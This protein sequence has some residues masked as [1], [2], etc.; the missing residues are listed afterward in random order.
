MKTDKNWQ[1]LCAAEDFSHVDFQNVLNN[2]FQKPATYHRKQW[3]F[4]V[5]YLNLLANNKIEKDMVGASFG[6]G[7]EPLIYLIGSQ[8][9]E[10][11]A[12][13]LYVFNTGWQTAKINE[14]QTCRD[15]VMEK[16]P[17]NLDVSGILVEEM[18]MRNLDFADSSLDFCYSS[19]AFEH[20]GHE[21]DFIKHLEEV[22]RVL[23]ED[24]VYVMTTEYLFNHQTFKIKGNYKFDTKYM[25]KLFEASGLYP[26][27]VFDTSLQDSILNKTKMDLSPI[28][29]MGTA[30]INSIPSIILEKQGVPYT[31]CCFVLRKNNIKNIS[32]D[33]LE[34]KNTKDF[35]VKSLNKNIFKL[36]SQYQYLN[37]ISGLKKST[38][39][40]MADHLEYLGENFDEYF[41]EIKIESKNFLHTDFVYFGSFRCKFWI[42]V[43]CKKDIKCEIKLFEKDSLYVT[44]R[45]LVKS[46]TLD[47]SAGVE[48]RLMDFQCK[49]DKVYAVAVSTDQSM[50]FIDFKNTSIRVKVE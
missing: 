29:S 30:I 1:K 39:S 11:T 37:P 47:G 23:K 50:N 12:T 27:P 41:D 15:F 43:E 31:S 10:F 21:D 44:G 14:Q 49:D 22:K 32:L 13:D 9:K 24:G 33:E 25:L 8:V 18:D 2:I 40:V 35:V 42:H 17:K 45:V 34:N 38:K 4:V 26:D 6:A 36:Y 48:D 16:A 19:C 20:I 5:I 46:I 28:K 7:R 3:E